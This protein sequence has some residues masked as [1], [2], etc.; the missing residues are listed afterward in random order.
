MIKHAHNPEQSSI[1]VKMRACACPALEV[2][3]KNL[4]VGK[5]TRGECSSLVNMCHNCTFNFGVS[6]LKCLP[7]VTALTK[8]LHGHPHCQQETNKIMN[9]LVHTGSS[10]GSLDA[11]PF[12]HPPRP[13][14]RSQ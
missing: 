14:Q 2:E 1:E 9:T 5:A 12:P 3:S 8:F 10:Q 13:P 4:L 6:G 7:L 11:G